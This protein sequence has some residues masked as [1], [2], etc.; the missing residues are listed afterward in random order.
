MKRKWRTR[1]R[2]IRSGGTYQKKKT[3]KSAKAN[4]KVTFSHLRNRN[5]LLM[6]ISK[7]RPRGNGGTTREEIATKNRNMSCNTHTRTHIQTNKQTSILTHS[8][9]PTTLAN[10]EAKR[11]NKV[12]LLLIIE[13]RDGEL[14]AGELKKKT[15]KIVTGTSTQKK[16]LQ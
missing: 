9:N 4:E 10:R 15:Q 5:S 2:R 14:L 8:H 12:L 13:P 7:I 1:R 11:N 6:A 3:R 16:T